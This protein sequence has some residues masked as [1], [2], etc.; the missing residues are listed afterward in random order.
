MDQSD[1]RNHPR[2]PATFFGLA[3]DQRQPGTP[4]AVN[5]DTTAWEIYNDRAF[6]IDKELIKDWN[7]SLNTLLI[8]VSSYQ[9]RLVVSTDPLSRQRFTPLLS[10]PLLLRA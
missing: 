3:R 8:F 7:D 6:A 4:L 9:C 1:A 10:P 5:A 2:P